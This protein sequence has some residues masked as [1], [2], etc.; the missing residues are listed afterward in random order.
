MD[1]YIKR[2]VHHVHSRTCA[3]KRFVCTNSPLS[4]MF[5]LVIQCSLRILYDR[6]FLLVVGGFRQTDARNPCLALDEN[7]VMFT[8]LMINIS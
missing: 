8:E 3:C 5:R 7:R 2:R 6:G 1:I 4:G